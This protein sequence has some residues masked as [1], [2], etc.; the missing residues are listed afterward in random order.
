M[1]NLWS[2]SKPLNLLA[3]FIKFI[4][5]Q[6]FIAISFNYMLQF[7]LINLLACWH[8]FFFRNLVQLFKILFQ[9]NIDEIFE[10]ISQLNFYM[11]FIDNLKSY[12]I[13]QGLQIVFKLWIAKCR[14]VWNFSVLFLN[15]RWK[16]SQSH[17]TIWRLI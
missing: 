17:C 16:L 9:L 6:C 14:K 5:S 8:N 12:Y 15:C 13:I 11:V 3:F 2:N 4:L 1:L 7:L 10:L